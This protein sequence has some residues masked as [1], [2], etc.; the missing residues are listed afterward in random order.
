MNCYLTTCF[1]LISCIS[2]LFRRVRNPVER[3]WKSCAVNPSIHTTRYMLNVYM[4]DIW[5]ICLSFPVWFS[6]CHKRHFPSWH[7]HVYLHRDIHVFIHRMTCT[8][9]LHHD[10][11]LLLHQDMHVFLYIMTYTCFYVMTYAC[12]FT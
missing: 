7:T 3:L 10:F 1:T 4:C 9:F 5:Y 8:C 2:V 6:S 11:H 12:L